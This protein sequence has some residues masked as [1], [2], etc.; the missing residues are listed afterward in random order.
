MKKI[1]PLICI[2]LTGCSAFKPHMQTLAITA[3][4]PDS[5]LMVN[6]QRYTAPA[7]IPVKRN[8]DVSISCYKDGYMPYVRTVGNHMNGT[9][10]LDIVGTVLFLLPGIGLLTPGAYDLDETTIGISLYKK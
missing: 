6:G 2:A 3:D 1:F 5:V 10:T 7:Q 9:G 4:P 8:R